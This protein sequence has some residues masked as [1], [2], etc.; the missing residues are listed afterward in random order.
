MNL[1]EY[2]VTNNST[3]L[4]NPKNILIL[5]WLEANTLCT[6]VEISE[7]TQISLQEVN[8]IIQILYKNYLI[9]FKSDKNI[10]I[11]FFIIRISVLLPKRE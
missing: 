7:K 1:K 11:R 5:E 4:D 8:E 2:L 3:L 10:F 9:S 6:P